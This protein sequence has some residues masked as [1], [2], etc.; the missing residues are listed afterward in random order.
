MQK[1]IYENSVPMRLD[2]FLSE[3]LKEVSR[4]QLKKHIDNGEVLVNDKKVKA[5]FA[6]QQ[7]DVITII[8]LQN[9]QIDL[10]PQNIPLDVIFENE[11]YAIIN[12]PQGMV[13]HPA[14]GNYNGTLVNALLY[15]IKTLSDVNG[16]Y[17]PGIV[18]R[19]DKDTSGLIVI[20][21]NDKAHRILAKQIETKQCKRYYLALVEGI[22]REGGVI[23]TNI[24]RSPKDRKK[25]AVCKDNQGKCATTIFKVVK[26][27]KDFTLLECELK[28]GRT[29]QI[30]VHCN[31][32]GHPIV[33]DF[34]YGYKKQKFKTNGQLLHA[35]KLSLLDPSTKEPKT[36]ECPLPD[37]FTDI[38][39]K[40]DKVK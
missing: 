6:L 28:T 17:R 32:I 33:G 40:L 22:V 12:K 18:H 14:V 9:P 35:Y 34:V 38:L 36:F 20:A 10:T 4:S 39:K 26:N 37:Y 23:Q 11:D 24:A 3:K 7:N 29:H 15:R 30:R 13:V 2:T 21:K 8:N 1:I 25:F 16:E 31:Y 5:G 27:Y 19:L